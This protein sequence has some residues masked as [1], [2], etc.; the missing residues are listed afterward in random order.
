MAES[1]SGVSEALTYVAARLRRKIFLRA[2]M[3]GSVIASVLSIGAIV[4]DRTAV[5]LIPLFAS[6]ATFYALALVYA[7]AY[8]F[9][10]S[11]TPFDVARVAEEALGL[12][13]RLSSAIAL[14]DN[15]QRIDATFYGLQLRDANAIA[16]RLFNE[17]VVSIN[18]RRNAFDHFGPCGR[19]LADGTQLEC[20][21]EVTGYY[22]AP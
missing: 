1:A 8:S 22:R 6:L 17:D 7:M 18:V 15:P 3:H 14:A 19:L 4:I 10:V 21:D 13:E 16:R 5:L 20:L 2:L 12:R 9:V 11:L